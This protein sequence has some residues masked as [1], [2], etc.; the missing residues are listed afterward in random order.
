MER[1]NISRFPLLQPVDGVDA[2][3]GGVVDAG[4]VVLDERQVGRNVASRER[5]EAGV[6]LKWNKTKSE[7]RMLWLTRE[8]GAN[9]AVQLYRVSKHTLPISAWADREIGMSGTAK[10]EDLL[11]LSVLNGI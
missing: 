7:C 2:A 11:G 5:R 1:P 8:Q 4:A 10:I 6:N 3:V 9:T